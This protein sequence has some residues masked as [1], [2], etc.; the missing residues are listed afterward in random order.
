MWSPLGP[1]THQLGV[2]QF[3][4]FVNAIGVL[5]LDTETEEQGVILRTCQ[6]LSGLEETKAFGVIQHPCSSKTSGRV[7]E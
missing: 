6:T 1:T 3:L 4:L 7:S 5:G 2:L